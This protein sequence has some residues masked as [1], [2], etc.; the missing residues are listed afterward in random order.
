M[1]KVVL[2]GYIL[3]ADAH[4]P[5][6][7]A[8]LPAHIE[9]TRSEPGCLL[10]EVTQDPDDANR[11]NVYEEFSSQRAFALHQERVRRSSWGEITA[12]VERF[13]QVESL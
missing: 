11:F 1:P 13:Y 9:L 2:K 4:L 7:L 6:V 10:F 8:A 3:V 5:S 12:D